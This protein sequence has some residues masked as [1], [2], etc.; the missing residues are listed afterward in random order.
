MRR[1]FNKFEN[2]N[3]KYKL[4][5]ITT[6]LLIALAMI[7]YMILDFSLP[8]YYHKYK[9]NL[10]E[11][12]INELSDTSSRYNTSH[13][14]ERLYYMSR[15][16]NLSIILK[17]QNGKII[18]GN[19]EMVLSRYNKYILGKIPDN[20]YHVSMSINTNDSRIPYTLDI[21]MPLQPIDEANK[22][23]RKLMPFI[24]MV[25][26]II[27]AIG[28]YIY[29]KVITKPLIHIIESERE[30]ENRRKD[31]VATISHELKTPITIISGQLE[32][33]IYN[34]GKYKD[35]DTYLKKS[36]ESTQELKDLVN[37]MIEVSKNEILQSDLALTNVNLSSLVERLTKRHQFLIDEKNMNVVLN[38]QDNIYIKCDETR[39]EKAINN[40]II[41]GIKYSPNGEN[42]I[43][44]LY[45]KNNKNT[46]KSNQYRAYL[47]IENTGVTIDKRYLE[48]IFNP[49]FRIEKS[50]SRKTG[51]SGL[52]L[53]LVNQILK[54]HGYYHSLKNKENSVVF[55]I[56]F[57]N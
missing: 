34:I 31:F 51:G 49:F 47:E 6:G 7:I 19:S 52:G 14:Q 38:I 43:V 4:F 42:L 36:Y 44:K 17:N 10:L 26:L 3:I 25:A 41:N 55:T 35:R 12:T 22:V 54:S 40:I 23:I 56:E 1:V 27:G 11:K 45:K 9:I 8:T 48:Q 24:L 13:L 50:R 29:S 20:E 5:L 46:K 33:M 53:Y 32:G 2:I 16:Q 15:N 30:A 21:I 37:E 18:Y 57:K 28:A 39:I